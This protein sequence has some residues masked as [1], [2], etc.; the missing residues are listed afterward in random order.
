LIKHIFVWVRRPEGAIRLVGELATT[1]PDR[2]SGRFESE[3]EY[4][5][6]WASEAGAFALDPVSLPLDAARRFR[7]E[8][9]YPPHCQSSW[10][11]PHNKLL[12][13]SRRSRNAPNTGALAGDID[14]ELASQASEPQTLPECLE[15]L[16]LG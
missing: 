11:R 14:A 7:A 1:A 16:L 10:R 5:R 4:T 15:E 2:N 12:S 13:P 6:A 3:F 9:L 8:M